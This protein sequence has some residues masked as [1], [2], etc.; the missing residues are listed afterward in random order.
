MLIE[1]SLLINQYKKLFTVSFL[2]SNA[3]TMEINRALEILFVFIF[4]T[5]KNLEFSNRSVVA[6]M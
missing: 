5:I 1:I 4:Y 2:M 6:Q 3:T